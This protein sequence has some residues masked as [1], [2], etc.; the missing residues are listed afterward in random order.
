MLFNSTC[1]VL[2]LSSLYSTITRQNDGQTWRRLG[3]VHEL[4]GEQKKAE[5]ASYTAWQLGI[6]QG[7]YGGAV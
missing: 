1:T 4:L 6:G 7:G 2:T 3:I 5:E